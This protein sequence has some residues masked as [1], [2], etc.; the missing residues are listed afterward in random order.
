MGGITLDLILLQL[1]AGISV[2]AVLVLLALG[3]SL[4]FGMLT[5]VNFAHGAFFMIGAYCGVYLFGLTHNF[6]V[7]LVLVPLVMGAVGLVCERWLIR[8][9][10]GRGIDYPLLLTFGLSYVLI[11]LVRIL[12]GREGIPFPTPEGLRGAAD[13]GF[14]YFPKYRLFLIAAT[15][16]I[17]AAIW[18]FVEKTRYGLIIRAGARDPEIVRILGIDVSRVWLAVFGLGTALAGLAGILIAPMQA[19][20]PEMGIPILAE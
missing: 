12:F 18:L 2:G 13:L 6:W 8:P 19:V 11:E 17:V 10:Y 4:I 14:G 3:L 5:V 15:A 9:L 1:V 16:L 7:S 20:T